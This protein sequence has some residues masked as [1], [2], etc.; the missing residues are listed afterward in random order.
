MLALWCGGQYWWSF[1]CLGF[2]MWMNMNEHNLCAR[3]FERTCTCGVGWCPGPN[4]I[5]LLT[6]VS[7]PNTNNFNDSKSCLQ[8]TW[9]SCGW[10]ATAA[11]RMIQ[12]KPECKRLDIST[13]AIY[14]WKRDPIIITKVKEILTYHGCHFEE[15]VDNGTSNSYVRDDEFACA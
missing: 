7:I 13:K 3:F 11:T 4:R 9:C 15:S 5:A 2:H 12:Q 10:A 6:E 8:V 1:H 14:E